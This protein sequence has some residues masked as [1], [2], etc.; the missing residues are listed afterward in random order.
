MK[1]NLKHFFIIAASIFLLTGCCTTHH[2]TQWEYKVVTGP[3]WTPANKYKSQED[4]LKD[5]EAFMDDLG[6][7]GWIYVSET[8][9]TFYFKRPVK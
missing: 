8:D 6:K 7:D 1:P 4:F 2:V 5:R 3:R 9:N